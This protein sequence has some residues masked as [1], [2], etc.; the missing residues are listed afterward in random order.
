MLTL[1]SQGACKRALLLMSLLFLQLASPAQHRPKNSM[2]ERYQYIALQVD[3]PGCNA[4]LLSSIN[5]T[6][7]CNLYV[8]PTFFP[9]AGVIA[10]SVASLVLQL[11]LAGRILATSAAT[12]IQ[13]HATPAHPAPTRVTMLVTAPYRN[14]HPGETCQIHFLC[15]VCRYV[16][17]K[18][19][20]APCW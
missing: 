13:L 11:R 1:D 10:P 5:G 12:S 19:Y 16:T 14:L 3:L 4:T 17:L 2:P 7:N 20:F 8:A 18:Q 9:A 6:A 15:K